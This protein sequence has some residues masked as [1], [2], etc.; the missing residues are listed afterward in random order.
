MN[1]LREAMGVVL[2]EM[3]DRLGPVFRG[4]Q[5]IQGQAEEEGGA[6]EVGGKSGESDSMNSKGMEDFKRKQKATSVRRG[7]R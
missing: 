2:S 4:N 6:R 1:A 3:R 7:R 5:T